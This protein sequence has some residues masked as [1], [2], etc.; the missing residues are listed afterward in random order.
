MRI[1]LADDAAVAR[2]IFERI[3]RAE[4]HEVV[5]AALDRDA[6]LEQSV[7]LLPDVVVLDSRFPPVGGLSALTALRELPAPPLVIVSAALG[8]AEFLQAALRSGASGG[9][10]R[11][12][13]AAQVIETLRRLART[14]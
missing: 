5:G 10:F 9:L 12:L 1:L 6:L 2:A 13:R 8:E 3:A 4:G 14:A 7:R 11:P